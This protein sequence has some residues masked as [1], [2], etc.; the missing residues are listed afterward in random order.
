MMPLLPVA[1][2][3]RAW[4]RRVATVV[5]SRARDC[6]RLSPPWVMSSLSTGEGRAEEE[7]S[8][9]ASVVAVFRSVRQALLSAA[10]SCF[11]GAVG[12]GTGYGRV[13]GVLLA[14]FLVARSRVSGNS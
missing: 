1:G 12:V 11:A 9:A 8:W 7:W 10:A 3:G 6:V 4:T 13:G 2:G 5:A 14:L